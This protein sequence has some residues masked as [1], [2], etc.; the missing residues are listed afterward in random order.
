MDDDDGVDLSSLKGWG[1]RCPEILDLEGVKETELQPLVSRD[2]GHY[3][4]PL[5]EADLSQSAEGK[6]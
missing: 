5:H 4:R 1:Q 6:I 3:S 2:H